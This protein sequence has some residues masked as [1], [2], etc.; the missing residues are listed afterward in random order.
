[1][2]DNDLVS[3]AAFYGKKLDMIGHLYVRP[4]KMKAAYPDVLFFCL[5][6]TRLLVDKKL[7]LPVV[8]EIQA[9]LA[10]GEDLKK[11]VSRAEDSEFS[12]PAR[13]IGYAGSGRS[14][15]SASMMLDKKLQFRFGHIGF[16][17]FS[18]GR[19][20]SRC[21]AASIYGMLQTIYRNNTEDL[22]CLD[23][24][25]QAAAA[26][27]QLELGREL[28]KGNFLQVAQRVYTEITADPFICE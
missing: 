14:A 11:V 4:P 19:H 28:R 16:G 7:L 1:M 5:Y 20:F 13:V 22:Q 25:W 6:T 12:L 21:A 23:Y 15:F 18:N 17:L 24:L 8:K 2:F 3:E 9:R 10:L 27:S 26:I